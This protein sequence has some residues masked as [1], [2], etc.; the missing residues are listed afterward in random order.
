[1]RNGLIC[2]K[3]DTSELECLVAGARRRMPPSKLTHL[4][5]THGGNDTVMNAAISTM[6]NSNRCCLVKIVCAVKQIW[7]HSILLDCDNLHPM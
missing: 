3:S 5:E 2:L 7:F 1:M 6:I 4:A